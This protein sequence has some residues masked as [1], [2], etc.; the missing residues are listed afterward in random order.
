M[1]KYFIVISRNNFVEKIGLFI[2]RIETMLNIKNS[3]KFLFVMVLLSMNLLC[4]ASD[5]KTTRMPE[6]SN[7]EVDVWKT[8]IYPNKNQ[9]LKMHRH[10][11]NR[12]VVALNNGTLKIT[13]DKGKIHYLNLEK[14]H[15]YYLTKDV[16]NEL[17]SD[18][19]IGKHPITVLVIELKR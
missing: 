16:P 8:I 1:E 7:N 18:E 15:A 12:V 2:K 17:H 3:Q 19:N 13:N 14:D 9:R 6:F 4:F 11:Y 5:I 10:E